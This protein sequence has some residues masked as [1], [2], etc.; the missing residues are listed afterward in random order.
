MIRRPPRST[1]TD[2]LFPYT[3]L[4]RSPGSPRYSRRTTQ[5]QRRRHLDWAS[6]RHVRCAYGRPCPDRGEKAW[7]PARR[8]D[9]VCRRRN[10]SGGIV[11][12]A[13]MKALLSTIPGGP[14]T[15]ELRDV[16]IPDPAAGELRV[17][18]LACAI[19]YPDVLIIRSE[20]HTA[21]LQSP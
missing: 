16:P 10:G 21:E 9:N 19:N 8:G 4:V 2:T 7:R 17:R 13:L 12:G 11:R 15:L 14:E 3:T 5:R 20:E 18:V 1:R 6:L